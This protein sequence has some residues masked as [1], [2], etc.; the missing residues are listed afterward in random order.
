[1]TTTAWIAAPEDADATALDWTTAPDDA[2][3]HAVD[4]AGVGEWFSRKPAPVVGENGYGYWDM[5]S[6]WSCRSGYR[7]V[8]EDD[9]WRATLEQRPEVHP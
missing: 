1:M 6:G 9:N 8:I 7:C 4:S 3:W 5:P 2:L